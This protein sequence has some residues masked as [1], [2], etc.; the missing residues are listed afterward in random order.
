MTAGVE[1]FYSFATSFAVKINLT[2]KGVYAYQRVLSAVFAY[3][4][5]LTDRHALE[6]YYQ[7]TA[8]IHHTQFRFQPKNNES[9]FV[10][11]IVSR[12]QRMPVRFI[13]HTTPYRQFDYDH[14]V[15]LLSF[16]TPERS[17]GYLCTD[18]EF[19]KDC[20]T[21]KEPWYG[22]EYGKIP[23]RCRWLMNDQHS[24]KNGFVRI[25]SSLSIWISL[26]ITLI[27]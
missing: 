18:V 12:L 15:E 21:E 10:I 8:D 19:M 5:S 24:Y 3:I 26:W 25:I 11:N 16:L 6:R 2:E 23:T 14:L 22:I 9:A 27:L 4:S 13:L 20:V 7:E 17:V 1:S